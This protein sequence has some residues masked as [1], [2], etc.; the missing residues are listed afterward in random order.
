MNQV[1]FVKKI[2]LVVNI[3]QEVVFKI[4]FLTLNNTDNDFLD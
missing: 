2:F 1:K 4:L 3:S